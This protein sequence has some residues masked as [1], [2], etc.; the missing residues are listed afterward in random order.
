MY[1]VDIQGWFLYKVLGEFKNVM[2]YFKFKQENQ[3]TFLPPSAN[4]MDRSD[5]TRWADGNILKF[6]QL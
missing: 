2:L 3:M 1:P 5:I 4:F 6:S